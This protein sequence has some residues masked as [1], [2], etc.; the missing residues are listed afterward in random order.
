MEAMNDIIRKVRDE[1]EAGL[2][3]RANKRRKRNDEEEMVI[4]VHIE[5]T[6]SLGVFVKICFKQRI[7]HTKLPF[8]AF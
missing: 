7:S 6:R 1:H 4:Y 5:I 3:E 2:E 8:I